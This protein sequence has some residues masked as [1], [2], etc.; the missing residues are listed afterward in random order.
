MRVSTQEREK[1]RGRERAVP[2]S[3][4]EK[5]LHSRL[6]KD[7]TIVANLYTTLEVYHPS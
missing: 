6:Q 2:F 3:S 5:E 7:Q 1:E 4:H